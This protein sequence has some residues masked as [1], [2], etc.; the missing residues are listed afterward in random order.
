MN[1][2]LLLLLSS[3]CG[4]WVCHVTSAPPI[5]SL[6]VTGNIL[7][8]R[9]RRIFGGGQ[10]LT[11]F[12]VAHGPARQWRRWRSI[13][14]L[15]RKPES[16]SLSVNLVIQ[17]LQCGIGSIRPGSGST[18]G[19]ALRRSVRWRRLPAAAVSASA[20]RILPPSAAD[21][22]SSDQVASLQRHG[23]HNG[24]QSDQ[25]WRHGQYNL[26]SIRQPE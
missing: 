14:Q 7:I 20:E 4:T 18:V 12:S 3:P 21:S 8:F 6:Q 5:V 2:L 24:G 25:R 9:I 10:H 17:F 11:A 13:G 26:C 16:I 19:V 15:P 23:D 1:T 22:I